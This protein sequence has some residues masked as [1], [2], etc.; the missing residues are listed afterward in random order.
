MSWTLVGIQCL[1]ATDPSVL[2]VCQPAIWPVKCRGGCRRGVRWDKVGSA[3][4][5][6]VRVCECAV[7]G[8]ASSD[9]D[10]CG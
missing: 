10:G 1:V 5:G 2:A 3:G 6:R 7:P 9:D 8:G 4:G